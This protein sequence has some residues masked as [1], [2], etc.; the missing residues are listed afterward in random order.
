MYVESEIKLRNNFDESERALLSDY[1]KNVKLVN[2]DRVRLLFPTL[3]KVYVEYI[4]NKEINA[5][6]DALMI[7]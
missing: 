1:V 5:R 7:K 3:T 4:C 6:T 2:N